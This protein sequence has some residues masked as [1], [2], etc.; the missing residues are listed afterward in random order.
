M[1][2]TPSSRGSQAKPSHGGP[3]VSQHKQKFQEKRKLKEV[4]A[5]PARGMKETSSQGGSNHTFLGPA[6]EAYT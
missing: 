2:G 5:W 3:G 1:N 4:S 6:P